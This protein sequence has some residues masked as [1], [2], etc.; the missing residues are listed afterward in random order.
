MIKKNVKRCQ[1][2]RKVQKT[3]TKHENGA[4]AMKLLESKCL[5]NEK[6]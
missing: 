5:E 6:V 4:K 2:N 1:Q 3:N